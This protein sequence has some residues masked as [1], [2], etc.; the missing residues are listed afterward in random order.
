M[1]E[2]VEYFRTFIEPFEKDYSQ[3]INGN[4]DDFPEGKMF[5]KG[6]NYT[7]HTTT[8]EVFLVKF[9]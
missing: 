6:H 7:S 5:L 1:E 2:F 3:N 4:S 9:I 8:G